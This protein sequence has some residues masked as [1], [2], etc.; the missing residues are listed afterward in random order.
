MNIDIGTS[1]A[2]TA[3]SK[4]GHKITV[5]IANDWMKVEMHIKGTSIRDKLVYRV[6]RASEKLSVP[7]IPAFDGLFDKLRPIHSSGDSPM[8]KIAQVANILELV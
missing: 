4:S 1:G 3:S 8:N 6:S 2:Q 5:K 7:K